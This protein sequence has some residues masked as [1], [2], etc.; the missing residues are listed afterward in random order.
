MFAVRS[1]RVGLDAWEMRRGLLLPRGSESKGE[2]CVD[3]GG[4]DRRKG[5]GKETTTESDSILAVPL[6]LELSSNNFRL[7]DWGERDNGGGILCARAGKYEN[8]L[9]LCRSKFLLNV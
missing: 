8:C 5:K 3:N 1:D 6:C 9:Y 4:G 2:S 7:S